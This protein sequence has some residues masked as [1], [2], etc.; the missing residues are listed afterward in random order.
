[1]KRK[2]NRRI[3]LTSW[4]CYVFY[5]QFY[6]QE[7]RLDEGI[8]VDSLFSGKGTTFSVKEEAPFNSFEDNNKASAWDFNEIS[9]I[10]IDVDAHKDVSLLGS[11]WQ[12]LSVP[13]TA[14]YTV[15]S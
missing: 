7:V 4:I 3:S 9:P 8:D 2:A 1:M 14:T 11:T 13:C 12:M 15:G 10:G 5:F 6:K